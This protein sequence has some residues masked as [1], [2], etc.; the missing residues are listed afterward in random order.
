MTKLRALRRAQ[1][2]L[3]NSVAIARLRFDVYL[4]RREETGY[5]G[6]SRDSWVHD[7]GI[8]RRRLQRPDPRADQTNAA[9]RPLFCFALRQDPLAIVGPFRVRQIF[10]SAFGGL[11]KFL[12]GRNLSS[13]H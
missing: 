7:A 5:L 4:F 2:H 9:G 6:F 11:A 8:F 13:V 10:H 3:R 12:L 1:L